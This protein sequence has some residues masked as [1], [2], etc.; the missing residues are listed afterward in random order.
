VVTVTLWLPGVASDEA[1]KFAV[2]W[3]ELTSV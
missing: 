3:V 2:I 1:G